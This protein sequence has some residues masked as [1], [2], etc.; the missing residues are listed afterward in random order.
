MSPTLATPPKALLSWVKLEKLT[1][2]EKTRGRLRVLHSEDFAFLVEQLT[3]KDEQS[4]EHARKA[5]EGYRQWMACQ[6]VVRDS[7]FLEHYFDGERRRLAMPSKYVDNVWHRHILFTEEYP[8]FCQLIAGEMIHHRPCTKANVQIMNSAF[9]LRV[10][11][12]LFGELP[13]IWLERE[14]FLT[15]EKS[16][17]SG[18]GNGSCNCGCM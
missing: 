13:E 7:L 15:A 11:N 1:L 8:Q 10:Y 5:V 9:F 2:N 3:W 17:C 18:C 4:E 6:I 12:L 14:A 16:G